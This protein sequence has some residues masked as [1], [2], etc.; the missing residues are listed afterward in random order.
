MPS[1]RLLLSTG[2]LYPFDTAHC[3]QLAAETGFDGI[4]IMC[5]DRYSTRDPAYLHRLMQHYNLPI[6]VCHTPFSPHLPGWKGAGDEIGRIYQTLDLA[7]KLEAPT[8]VVHLPWRVGWL[9]IAANHRRWRLPWR[10]PYVG[11][12]KW[13]EDELP[14]IQA[15]TPVRIALENMPA[16]KVLGWKIDPT[17]WNEIDTWAQVHPWLT[18]DTT[19][20]ATKDVNPLDAYRAALGRV[21][22][23]HLSNYDGREHR[24]P[25][26]GH[27]DLGG[28]L[29]ALSNDDYKGTI[30]LELEPGALEFADEKALRRNLQESLNFCRE[31]M[32]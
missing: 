27:L 32:G 26:R 2:S 7:L 22:H 8:I 30:S 9:T 24:L 5:D 11:V 25:H 3:F 12:K 18:L 28:F 6:E 21:C 19:H 23:V 4:E 20:W 10:S 13:I 29:R 31:H 15:A 1:P 17:W 14:R 16:G